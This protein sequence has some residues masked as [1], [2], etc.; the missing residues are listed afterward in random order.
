MPERLE[1]DVFD[2]LFDDLE[3]DVRFEKS[4]ADLFQSILDVLLGELS[5]AAQCTPTPGPPAGASCAVATTLDAI[6]PGIVKERQRAIWELGQ[7]E[8]RDGGA[9]GLAA[10]PPNSRFLVQGLF[11]P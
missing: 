8:V 2:E 4:Q 6:V 11:V 5:L 7:V 9:D 1:L 3:I 10:T